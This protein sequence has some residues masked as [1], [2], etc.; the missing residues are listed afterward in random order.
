MQDLMDVE[1]HR[2]PAGK[3]ISLSGFPTKGSEF[4]TDKKAAEK[5]FKELRHELAEWQYRLYAESKQKLLLIFQAPDTGGKDGTIRRVFAGVDLQGVQITAFKAPTHPELSRDFLWRVHQAVPPAGVIGVF[6]R[7]HYEDVL[8]ARVD[9]LVPEKVW[10]PRYELINQFEHLLASTGTTIVKFYLHISADEQK[11]RLLERLED[12]EKNW[13][14]D[15]DDLRKRKQ[16]LEY[17]LAYQELLERCNTPYA[18]WYVIPADQ[19]WYRNLA[20]TKVIVHTLRQM[21]PQF[22]AVQHDLSQITIP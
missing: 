5:E 2:L 22:P 4:H 17:K 10:R 16:W 3:S 19:N 7:S 12:P 9:N 6:N 15:P 21:N 18:P 11:E 13:K 8:I 14:F 20:V 1:I